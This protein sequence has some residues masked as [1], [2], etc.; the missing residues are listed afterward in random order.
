MLRT[1]DLNYQLPT[2]LIATTPAEPRDAARLMV[3]SRSEPQ[4]LEHRA[5]RD[6]PA[7]FRAPDLLVRNVSRVAPARL[8]G[9]RRDTGGRFEGLFL[10]E[11]AT[12][13]N[14][15]LWRALL[16]SNGR[17]RPGMALVLQDANGRETDLSLELV[18]RDGPAWIVR[19]TSDHEA[20]ISTESA[21][22]QAGATPLP[23]YIA[24][25]RRER[26]A[27]IADDADRA[28]YQTL[29][30]SEE[31]AGSVAAPT[32]GLHFTDELLRTLHEHG[33]SFADVIL[34]VGEGTFRP[35]EAERIEDHHMHAERYVV[36][37]ATL[38]AIRRARAAGGR[39][40]AIGTTT[41]RALESVPESHE[42]DA[43]GE[44]RLL[45]A[46]GH[47]WRWIDGL[48]TN[49]HLPRS[50]LLAMVSSLFPEGPARL[51]GLY[52]E[53]IREGY[54]FY[55]YGDAMLILP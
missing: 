9:R 15:P 39:S 23:P 53:A 10:E 54:R 1:D 37:A 28:W 55:S 38:Q 8:Q 44:T 48:M 3:V 30:A 16:K 49:F 17:L 35:V 7:F 5:V 13:D 33:V 47:E 24:S 40:I 26:H 6:L 2:D 52:E 51:L 4:L 36:P 29:Y 41:A 14:R 27:E 31:R 21:L 12:G 32:A 18:E 19:P 20:P 25:A 45:I 22:D 34:H 50:T 42:G 43:A 46:P 11:R